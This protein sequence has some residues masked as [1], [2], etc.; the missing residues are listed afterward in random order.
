MSIEL[1]ETA[2]R[3]VKTILQQPV[4]NNSRSWLKKI[5]VDESN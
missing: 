2:A 4:V 3:E 1:T 5:P